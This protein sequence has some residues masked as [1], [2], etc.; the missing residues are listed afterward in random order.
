MDG[1]H[2]IMPE[3]GSSDQVSLMRQGNY[4]ANRSPSYTKSEYEQRVD[5]AWTFTSSFGCYNGPCKLEPNDYC[6]N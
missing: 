1:V 5:E 6:H 2:N 4:T 3:R